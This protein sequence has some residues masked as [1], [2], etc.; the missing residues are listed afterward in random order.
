MQKNMKQKIVSLKNSV[1][2]FSLIEL[3]VSMAIGMFLIAGVFSVF[4]NSNDSRQAVE[5][6]VKMLDDARFA[7]DVIAYD[8]RHAGLW[9]RLKEPDFVDIS[10]V[11][12]IAGECAAGWTID[13][14]KPVF[15]YDDPAG[16]APYASCGGS[17]YANGG[18]VVEM[19]YTMWQP[20]AALSAGTVYLNGDANQAK[21]HI[22]DNTISLSSVAKNYRFVANAYYVRSWSDVAGDG[23][24]SLHQLSLQ[25]GTGAPVV[26]DNLILSGVE[27]LQIQYGMDMN[28]DGSVNQYVSPGDAAMDW[29][30]VV[31][32][33]VWLIVR[34]LNYNMGMDTSKVFVAPPFTGGQISYASDGYKR[35]MLSTVV[36]LRDSAS[37]Y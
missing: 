21:F 10:A 24:P 13:V 28:G 8:L 29:S 3:M 34:S 35:Q 27:N 7:L 4:V 2:G 36:Q 12:A 11:G 19:R 22:S 30:K 1:S 9:G 25:P 33:Q 26:V 23:I 17:F 31:T 15:A 37:V 18:D 20:I 5:A 16:V 14:S 6:E 32:A